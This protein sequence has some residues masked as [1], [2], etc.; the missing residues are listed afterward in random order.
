MW[1]HVEMAELCISLLVMHPVVPFIISLVTL[2]L[3]CSLQWD[4]EEN[5]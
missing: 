5:L 2:L 4:L 3:A 1:L